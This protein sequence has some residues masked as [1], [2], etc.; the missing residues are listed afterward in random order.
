MTTY[1]QALFW[2]SR[3]EKHPDVCEYTTKSSD[4]IKDGKTYFS[5]Y[6]RYLKIG[7]PTE[8]EF[9]SQIFD[10]NWK[11]W[12]SIQSSVALQQLGLDTA[13]WPRALE[14]QIKSKM[15]KRITKDAEDEESKTGPASAKWMAEG[16]Y[17]QVIAAKPKP[18]ADKK[19]EGLVGDI[20]A[21]TQADLDR[22][23]IKH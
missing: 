1:T 19:P 5:M 9:V 13:D 17:K 16:K 18:K 20:A 22:L 11:Q 23:G 12:Q 21:E 4:I 7:D 15:V 6:K 8:F 14:M 10:G 2:E 3:N